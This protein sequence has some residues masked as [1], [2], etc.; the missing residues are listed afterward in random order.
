MTIYRGLIGLGLLIA[1][2]AIALPAGAADT[3][4]PAP[5]TMEA[6][7]V[8]AAAPGVFLLQKRG[9]ARFHLSV[10]GHVFSSREAIENYLAYRAAELIKSQHG[11]W[12][13]LVENRAKGDTVATPRPDPAGP[14]FSFRMQY[15]RPLWR[16][17]TAAS[18]DWKSWSPFSGAAFFA[19][20][21]KAITTYEASADIVLHK[22]MLA[23]DNPLAF[24][25][26]ALSDFLVNQV[27]PPQ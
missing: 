19:A 12:F 21:P 20:D 1:I 11:G 15:W 26:E 2:P 17:K 27:S 4:G 9:A 14:R 25:A 22:G 16:Y 10:T 23:D 18:P 24:D 7:Q 3:A 13:T 5:A 8:P 6:P